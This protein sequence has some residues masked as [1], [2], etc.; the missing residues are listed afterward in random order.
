[1]KKHLFISALLATACTLGT[2][3][4]S[5]EVTS[6][7]GLKYKFAADRVEDITFVQTTPAEVCD[8]TSVDA[9]IYSSG[10]VEAHSP[11][12]T[13]RKQLLC[14]LSVRRWQ[15]ISMTACIMYQPMAG[16]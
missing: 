5:I 6:S 11:L 9:R 14:G 10:T 15:S 4:Q 3:A 8:F 12:R 2:S 1:M 13:I 7:D 16:Q